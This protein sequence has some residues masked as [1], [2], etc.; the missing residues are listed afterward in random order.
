MNGRVLACA[1]AAGQDE[2]VKPSQDRE[3]TEEMRQFCIGKRRGVIPAGITGNSVPIWSCAKGMP[4]ITGYR[5]DLDLQGYFTKQWQDVT[6]YS[7]ANMVGQIHS[8]FIGVWNVPMR[9]SLLASL[10]QSIL[11]NGKPVNSAPLT[12]IMLNMR[13]GGIGSSIGTITYLSQS[14]TICE[15]DMIL[16]SSGPRSVVFDERLRPARSS[17]RCGTPERLT[18]QIREEQLLVEWRAVGA[19]RPRKSAWGQRL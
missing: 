3:P 4:A 2:C 14:T 8:S 7:P 18:L 1:S 15:A 19:T 10:G 12:A 11:V 5:S 17:M 9:A 6:D 13:G 16:V